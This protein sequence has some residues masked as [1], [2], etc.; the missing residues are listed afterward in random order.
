MA[1]SSGDALLG[2]LDERFYRIAREYS[3]GRA[4][5]WYWFQVIIS[6]RPLAWE[7]MKRLTGAA[8]AYEAIRKVL[9]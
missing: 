5:F 6:L 8:A 1:D 7:C 9:K 3:P 4:R 2:D